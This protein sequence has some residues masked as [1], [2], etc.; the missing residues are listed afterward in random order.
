MKQMFKSTRKPEEEQM[1]SEARKRGDSM[2]ETQFQM[3]QK[4]QDQQ[5]RQ[6]DHQVK[7]HCRNR[8]CVV[9]NQCVRTW[10]NDE[11]DTLR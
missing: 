3:M 4:A 11:D 1:A 8:P 5:L 10:T 9:A 7:Q 6:Q 2:C